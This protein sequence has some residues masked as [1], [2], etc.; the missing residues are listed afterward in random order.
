[1]IGIS[2][3]DL[4]RERD[5]LIRLLAE[6]KKIKGHEIVIVFDG[7][8][9]GGLREETTITSGI[10]VIYSRL[11]EKADTVIKRI[12]GSGTKEWIV[13]SSDREIAACAWASGSVPV[14]SEMFQRIVEN[15]GR[16]LKGE[17]DRL[18]EE[19][20]VRRKGNSRTPSKREKALMRA[21]KKL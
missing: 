13:I 10:K 11:A 21:L 17:Y 4:G 2:H 8:K 15:A 7:W 14:S 6:Y 19:D 9:S 3:E 20:K 5:A 12:L 18:E 1:M 16:T